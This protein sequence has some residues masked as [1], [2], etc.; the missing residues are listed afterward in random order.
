M[1]RRDVLKSVLLAPL[2]LL[3]SM[4]ASVDHSPPRFGVK[5]SEMDKVRPFPLEVGPKGAHVVQEINFDS[6]KHQ[7][8]LR[9]NMDG[10][11]WVEDTEFGPP[12]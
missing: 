5:N 10:Q 11:G 7:P 2:G 9:N 3:F 12:R 4:G 1:F 6:F 8:C